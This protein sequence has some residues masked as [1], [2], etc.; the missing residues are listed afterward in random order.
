MNKALLIFLALAALLVAAGLLFP[1]KSKRTPL[2]DRDIRQGD[3]SRWIG[4][5]TQTPPKGRNDQTSE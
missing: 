4:K 2:N 3:T 5:I 1:T